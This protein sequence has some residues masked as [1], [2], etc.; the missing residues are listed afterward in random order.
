MQHGSVNVPVHITSTYAQERPGQIWS[1]FDY[2][3]CGNPT[4]EILEKVMGHLEHAE[5]VQTLNH[6]RSAVAVSLLWL[7]HGDE[8]AVTSDLDHDASDLMDEMR[9]KFKYRFHKVDTWDYSAVEKL[10]AAHPKI[11]MLWI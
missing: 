9:V 4:R 6:F 11:K 5:H 10:L 7:K 3:R 1:R 8:V 2:S